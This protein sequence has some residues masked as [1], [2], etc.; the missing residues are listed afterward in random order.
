MGGSLTHED[1]EAFVDTLGGRRISQ[2]E[3]AHIRRVCLGGSLMIV[4]LLFGI[5]VLIEQ[6]FMF[7]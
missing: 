7:N 4:T 1:V 2:Q 5:F 3:Y 6:L